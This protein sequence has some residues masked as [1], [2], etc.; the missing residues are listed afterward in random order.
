MVTNCFIQDEQRHKQKQINVKE[1]KMHP[2]IT[3]NQAAIE[4]TWEEMSDSERIQRLISKVDYL[5]ARDRRL[6]ERMDNLYNNFVSH[7]HSD[8]QVKVPVTL[9]HV[10]SM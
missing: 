2:D 1:G 4:K 6:T 3:C 10:V 5:L 9:N 8:G 7:S